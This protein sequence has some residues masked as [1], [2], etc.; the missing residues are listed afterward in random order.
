MT[1]V[2]SLI[3]ALGLTFSLS[4]DPISVSY[5]VAGSAGDWTL[6]F[7]VSN[8]LTGAPLQNFYNFGVLLSSE[9]ITGSPADFSINPGTS[10]PSTIGGSDTTYNNLWID[11][12]FF[13]G[14]QLPGTTTSGFEVTISDAVAPTSVDWLAFTVDTTFDS[15][16]PSSPYSGG[17]NFNTA[18]NP[19][20]EGVATETSATPEPTSLTLFGVGTALL[21]LMRRKPRHP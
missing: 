20:F 18:D 9:N 3:V 15:P 13:D 1:L 6:D 12:N 19:G 4:A 5:T 17:G 21:M 16:H 10:N 2:K 11:D 7:S 8:N 14:L